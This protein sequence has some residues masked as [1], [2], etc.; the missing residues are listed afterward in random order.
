MIWMIALG[1]F[2]N[3]FHYQRCSTKRHQHRRRRI[4]QGLRPVTVCRLCRR[5]QLGHKKDL[6]RGLPVAGSLSEKVTSR[7]ATN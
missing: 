3:A 1:V 6:P 5:Y 2:L 4:G 7:S